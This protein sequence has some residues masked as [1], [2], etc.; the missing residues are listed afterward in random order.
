MR[1]NRRAAIK[2][3]LIVSVGITFLPHCKGEN[4]PSIAL[5]NLDINGDDENLLA[6]VSETFIP[7]TNTPGAKDLSAHLFAMKMLDDCYRKE[8]QEKFITGLKDFEKLV[9]QKTGKSFT[10]CTATERESVLNDMDKRKT[11][12]ALSYFYATQKHLTIQ[13]Y[14]TSKFY[15]T[16]VHEYKL[17]P[18]KFSGCVPV[19]I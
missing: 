2:Q 6:E 14:T 13:A 3:F 12:D 4:K 17:V 1:V 7:A 15:L 8:E 11:E 9:K 18:G 5:R 10:A 16:Q 19:K